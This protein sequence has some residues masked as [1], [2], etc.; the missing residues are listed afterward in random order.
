ME[1]LDRGAAI[2]GLS[3]AV[4]FSANLLTLLLTWVLLDLVEFVIYL[5]RAQNRHESERVVIHYAIRSA[6]IG[7]AMLAGIAAVNE[8]SSFAFGE[9]SQTTSTLLLLSAAVRLGLFPNL[10]IL[11]S[12]LPAHPGYAA[13]LRLATTAAHLPLLVFAARSGALPETRGIL[14]MWAGLTALL[15]AFSWYTL[16]DRQ[17]ARHDWIIGVAS[18]VFASA[19]VGQPGATLTWGLAMLLPG[20]IILLSTSQNRWGKPLLLILAISLCALPYTPAWTGVMLYAGSFHVSWLLFLPAQALLLAGALR[21]LLRKQNIPTT[22]ER[23]VWFVYTWGLLL[24]ILIN[25]YLAWRL[26]SDA[27]AL[28][29]KTPSLW[30]TWPAAASLL[31]MLGGWMMRPRIPVKWKNMAG[32]LEAG[33]SFTWII[34]PFWSFYHLQRRGFLFIS[35]ALESQPGI[36]WTLLILVLIVSLV[37]QTW[38]GG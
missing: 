21:H 24:L 2:A 34:K 13:F 38:A 28:G 27:A 22:Q 16:R 32:R 6:G 26:F 11:P 35:S 15:S 31:L 8:G 17:A 23:W 1:K 36:L 30:Q 3:L 5:S 25:F 9:L 29:E 4:I 7:L 37:S 20:G 10:H 33:F 12:N 19:V 18:L 14:F